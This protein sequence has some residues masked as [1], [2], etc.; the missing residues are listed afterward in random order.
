MKVVFIGA[1]NVATHLATELYRQKSDIV[2]VYS[3]T[4]K[5]AQE[6]AIQVKA[7][8]I[9]NINAITTDADLYIF[10]VK[11]SVLNDLIGQMPETSGTWIHTAGSI[12]ADI[13]KNHIPDYGVLYPFQTFTKGRSIKWKEIPVFIEASNKESLDIIT[14]VANQLSD[15]VYELSS[16]KRKYI[17]LTGVF[18]CN[19]SNHMYTLSKMVLKKA[20][21]PFEIAL[22]LIDETCAKIH[23][24]SPIDAQ[25]GPAVRYDENVINNHLELIEDEQIKEIYKLISKNIYDIHQKN[26]KP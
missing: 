16:G 15:K 26:D 23:E 18:A 4:I 5:S 25:T 13:F 11:D 24:L 17:H 1:G 7:A 3:R 14:S 12:P 21:L 20:G 9:T 19:F 8:P 10:S 2:Q 22:P 6:L